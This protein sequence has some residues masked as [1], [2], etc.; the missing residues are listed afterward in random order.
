MKR[1]LIVLAFFALPA[2]ADTHREWR[3]ASVSTNEPGYIVF[4]DQ[5][6]VTKVG[7]YWDAFVL[8]V[9]DKNS[10]VPPAFKMIIVKREVDCVS[11]QFREL[12]MQADK[13]TGQQIQSLKTTPWRNTQPNSVAQGVLGSICGLIGFS[14]DVFLRSHR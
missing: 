8:N 4:V 6:S 12:A 2:W 1:L 13:A 9:F 11:I 14:E 3:V 10:P 7:P 5:A